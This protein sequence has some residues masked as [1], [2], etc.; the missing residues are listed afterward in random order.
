MLEKDCELKVEK[1]FAQEIARAFTCISLGFSC[2]KRS[3][4]NWYI[5]WEKH[6]CE[7]IFC[8]LVWNLC[9][10]VAGEFLAWELTT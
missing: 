10:S 7:S 6:K 4:K 5:F 2:L 3:S 8:V 1:R 9:I